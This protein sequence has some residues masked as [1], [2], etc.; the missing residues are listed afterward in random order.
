MKL[1]EVVVAFVLLLLCVVGIGY[2]FSPTR[3]MKSAVDSVPIFDEEGKFY[4][5]NPFE[6]EGKMTPGAKVVI[7]QEIHDFGRMALGET[8]THGFVVKNEGTEP[9][10]LAKGRSQCKCTLANLEDSEIP[11]GGEAVINLEWK[12]EAKGAFGQEAIIWT[13]D[14]EKP[15]LHL[16]VR[17]SMFPRLMVYPEDSWSLGTVK[18]DPVEFEGFVLTQIYENLEIVSVESSSDRL[19]F[20]VESVPVEEMPEPD[21]KAA[22]RITGTLTPPEEAQ[23]IKEHVVIKTNLTDENA[24]IRLDVNAV[25]LGP[26]TVVGPGWHAD[27]SIFSLERISSERG[28]TFRYAFILDEALPDFAITE[29]TS[30][31][32]F[33]DISLQTD[34]SGEGAA[35]YT[36][37]IKVPAKCPTGVWSIENPGTISL[38]TNHPKLPELNF[39]V[40]LETY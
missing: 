14:P 17:G 40:A 19:K 25:R 5:R 24:E 39:K 22:Y 13:S 3:Q 16:S 15:D 32:G 18:T 33:L 38:K 35:K 34:S 1:R 29:V 21:G 30:D 4:R 2:Y 28:K 27:L 23:A 8:G 7:A 36:L 31:P 20:K 6:D 26:L 10:K 12:P 37:V 9:L 11:P